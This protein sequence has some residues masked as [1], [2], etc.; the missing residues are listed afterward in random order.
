MLILHSSMS[1]LQRCNS[2]ENHKKKIRQKPNDLTRSST[3]CIAIGHVRRRI[4][5]YITCQLGWRLISSIDK[6]HRFALPPLNMELGGELG[7]ASCSKLMKRFSI[8]WRPAR[9]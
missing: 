9:N 5:V 6:R 8:L 2:L 4:F 1:A 7:T 3:L